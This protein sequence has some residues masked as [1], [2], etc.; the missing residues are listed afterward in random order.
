MWYE[1]LYRLLVTI[2]AALV[3]AILRQGIRIE[4]KD[5]GAPWV[6]VGL[7]ILGLVFLVWIWSSGWPK[8]TLDTSKSGS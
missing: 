7:L 5:W 3:L 6:G 8:K 1:V 2:L 4:F